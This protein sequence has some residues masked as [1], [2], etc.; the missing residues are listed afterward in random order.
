MR[1]GIG[2]SLDADPAK[3]AAEAAAQARAAVPKPD[4]ALVFGSIRMDQERLHRQLC[5]EF[6][7]AVLIGGSSHAQITN[8]GVT[9]DGLALL[10]LGLDGSRVRFASQDL[11]PDLREA[12]RALVRGLNLG[13]VSG[14]GR[15][16]LALVFSDTAAV[17]GGREQDLLLGMNDVLGPVPIFGGV[18]GAD[19][20]L[21]LSNPDWWTNYQYAGQRL[22]RH[23]ARL[24]LIDLPTDDFHVGFGFAHGWLPVGPVVELTGCQNGKICEIGGMP[25]FD[26]YRQFLGRDHSDAFFELMVQRYA[27]SLVV[28]GDQ[29]SRI[30]GPVACDFKDGSVSCYPVQDLQGRK[31]QL[32]QASREG[33][34]HGARAAAENCLQAL[35]GQRPDLVLVVSCVTRSS[36]LHSRTDRELEVIRSVF[37]EQV[38]VFGYYA[39]G[40]FC[41]CLNRYEEVVDNSL[42]LHGPHHHGM[43]VCIL[44]IKSK[45]PAQTVVPGAVQ[46]ADAGKELVRL[47]SLLSKSEEIQDQTESFLANF[48]RKSY[49]DGERIRKQNEI[50]HRYTPH[51]VWAKVGASVAAGQYELPE[52]EFNGCFLFM[53]VKGFTSYSE[54]YGPS[55]V[56]TALNAIFKPATETIYACGGDVDKFIGDC[57]FA[58]FAKPDEA[59]TAGRRL[60]E[61]FQDLKAKGSPF[62]VRIGINMGRAVRANVGSQ[63]RR[64]YT[65]IGDSVNTAQRLESNCTPGRLM[66]SEELYKQ[67]T[68][69]FSAAERKEIKV[70][71]KKAPVVVYELAL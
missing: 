31:V 2:L 24:A 29:R 1:I 71:G 57:I 44:A 19:Y 33:L 52:S 13:A 35:D 42:P 47:R 40:E 67:G 59:L 63:D 41:P 25:V 4:L 51:E 46:G 48:S 21:G 64:E 36:I 28:E 26:Y 30:V 45:R 55:E 11:G 69:K 50:I 65:F 68:V 8:A 38:P 39:G 10:L 20:D 7:P 16:P 5:R 70:K 18:C 22:A 17:T 49:L 14:S 34:L 27:F 60:L 61:L 37:G 12:G 43:T 3:A 9:K 15:R 53:D 66:V 23:A 6:D 54:E 58:V 32:I 62:Q 56:V